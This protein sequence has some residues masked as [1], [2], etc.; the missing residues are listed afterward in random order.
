MFPPW[1]KIYKTDN[2]RYETYEEAIIIHDNLIKT[3]KHL[4]YEVCE[5]PID[6][7]VD[8]ANYILNVIEYS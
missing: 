1:E 4:N 6:S 2:E 8:R 5:V 3:Y 7:V